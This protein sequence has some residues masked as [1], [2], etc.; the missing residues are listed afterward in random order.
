MHYYVTMNNQG[1]YELRDTEQVAIPAL[2]PYNSVQQL[3]GTVKHMSKFQYFRSLRNHVPL[4]PSHD[5]EFGA[6]DR[7]GYLNADYSTSLTFH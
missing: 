1:L 5:F 2:R 6:F 3:L 7:G 4:A